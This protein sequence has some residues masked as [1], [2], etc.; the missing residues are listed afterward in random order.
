MPELEEVIRRAFEIYTIAA[1]ETPDGRQ[2]R[3]GRANNGIHD[4]C[5]E[6]GISYEFV[7][8]ELQHRMN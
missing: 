8:A 4:L 3:L 7:K 2:I 5:R 6:Y 1:I